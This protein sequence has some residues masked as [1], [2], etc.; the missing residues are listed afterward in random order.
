MIR[1]EHASYMTDKGLDEYIRRRRNRII[2]LAVAIVIIAIGVVM[3]IV[4]CTGPLGQNGAVAANAV[5]FTKEHPYVSD[6]AGVY[7]DDL[8]GVSDGVTSLNDEW[9]KS[10]DGAQLAVVTVGSLPHGESIEQ[11]ANEVFEH[12]GPG[13]KGKDNGLLYVVVKSTHQDRLEVG[14]GLESKVTD[15]KAK[16][17]ID[18]AHPYYKNGDYASGARA[19]MDALDEVMDGKALPTNT[20]ETT[21]GIDWDEVESAIL[22]CFFLVMFIWIFAWMPYMPIRTFSGN[23]SRGGGRHSGGGWSS[24]GSSSSSSHGG[25]GGGSSGGGGA[26]GSW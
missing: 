16:A 2:I 26:S 10:G 22:A 24:S 4:R 25:F 18:K 11:Y 3:G 15:A 12:V 6:N 5:S 20:S 1:V 21:S 8:D 23:R 13:Q 7:G 19:V 14:Y 9:S 17:I